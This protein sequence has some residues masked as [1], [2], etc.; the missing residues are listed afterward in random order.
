M[1]LYKIKVN[2]KTYKVELEAIEEV[3]SPTPV[4]TKPIEEKK[5]EPAPVAAQPAAQGQEVLSPI[6]GTVNKV[7]VKLGDKV[8]KGTPLFIVEAMKLENEVVSPF[9]GEVAQILVEKGAS[10]ASKQKLAIIG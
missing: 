2:G 3:S 5:A 8:T 10:V 1:K 6:Q 7:L 4:A 9:D